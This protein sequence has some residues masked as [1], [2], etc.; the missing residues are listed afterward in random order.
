M[1]AD[2]IRL[3]IPAQRIY[4][5]NGLGT[6]NPQ[7][8]ANAISREV[9]HTLRPYHFLKSPTV[10]VNGYAPLRDIKNADLDFEIIRAA[11]L[12]WLK[13]K[14][15]DITGEIHWLGETLILT[16]LAGS[17]YGGNGNGFANFDFRPHEGAD[18]SFTAGVKNVNVHLLASDLS[19]PSN[20]L[21]GRLTGHF[22]LTSG[23]SE[24]WD[25]WN[26]YGH[27]GLR[28]GLIRE[29]PVFGFFSPILNAVSPG[30]GNWRATDAS[31]Q[32]AMTNGV[33][34][35]DSLEI[36]STMMRLEYA[37]TVDLQDRV[38][39]R[40]TAELLRDVWGAGPLFSAIF[41]PVS[42]IFEFKVTGTLQHPKSEP[43]YIPKFLLFMLHPF[44]T[45]EGIFP[46]ETQTN[47][48][49]QK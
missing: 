6:A 32:F 14:T 49:P 20:H 48:P 46:G 26:G 12:Q 45:V 7:S 35:T 43:V 11:P 17:F 8:V 15:P 19:S 9:G 1:Q 16:N 22:V 21:E 47:A 29:V 28:D 13:I 4:F 31:A 10:R 2:G 42:K 23:N 36:R 40:V 30:L 5:T 38:Q 33:F 37:G 41:W 25:T 39:A 44:R 27:A 3:D 34:F 18:F 24:H